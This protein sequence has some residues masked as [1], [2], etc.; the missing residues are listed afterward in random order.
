MRSRFE[1]ADGLRGTACL[2]VLVLHALYFFY[3]GLDGFLLGLPKIGVWLFF[4]LS[5]FL[6]TSKF[7]SDGFSLRAL[8]G[9]V[10]GRVLRILPLY[11]IVVFAYWWLG[12]AGIE[13]ED[14]VARALM[15]GGTYAHLW[16]VPVEFK[17]Y[18]LLPIVAWLLISSKKKFGGSACLAVGSLMIFLQQ[19]AWPYWETP[20]ASSDARWY[21]SCF[22]LGAMAAMFREESV[23]WATARNTDVVALLFVG[24]IALISPFSRY[25]FLG[26]EP[27]QYLLNKFA[28]LS[29]LCS[30]LMLFVIHGRGIAGRMVRSRG[31][32]LIG[33][34]SYPIYLIHWM[35]VVKVSAIYPGSF[36]VMVLAIALS[37]LLGGVIWY[38]LEVPLER[39]RYR[40]VA[41]LTGSK[42][43]SVVSARLPL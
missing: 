36:V 13:S 6:L 27:D 29:A 11:M 37:I 15:L 8:A 32:K 23:K 24:I 14:D 35:V 25:M 42:I 31:L 5:A 34:W 1:G 12:S 16:T 38:G 21:L 2:I 17:Y 39:L 20:A 28:Y 41:R 43:A 10:V 22:A 9:Y 18:F 26:L 7:E 3:N 4:V 19:A 30:V 40:I 33:R